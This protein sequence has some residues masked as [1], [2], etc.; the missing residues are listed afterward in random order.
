MSHPPHG[1]FIV[2][3]G[4]QEEGKRERSDGKQT[5]VPKNKMIVNK[6]NIWRIFLT[7]FKII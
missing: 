4:T 6:N 5:D 7:D 2:N 1:G 3:N